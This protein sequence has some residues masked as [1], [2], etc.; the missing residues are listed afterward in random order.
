MVPVILILIIGLST[1]TLEER[2]IQASEVET[3]I[4]AGEPA[5]FDNCII[6][7]DLNLSALKID[8]PVHFNHT[9]FKGDAYFGSSAFKGDA[10]FGSSEFK[11][12]AYFGSSEFNGNADFL[13]SVFNGTAYFGYSFFK[14]YANFGASVFKGDADFWGSAF[15]GYAY[16]G[17]SVFKGDADFRASVFIG[18]ADFRASEFKGDADF[19][20]SEFKGD[21]DFRASEFKGDADFGYSAFNKNA[22]FIDSQFD[23]AASFNNASFSKGLLQVGE[24]AGFFGTLDLNKSSINSIDTYIRWKNINHLKFNIKTYNLLFDNYKKWR[25]FEDYNDCYY[26]FRKE[27]LFH[28]TLSFTKL[29][30]YFQW[31]LNGFGMKP[32]FPVVWSIGIILISGSIFYIANGI[33]RSNEKNATNVVYIPGYKIPRKPLKERIRR[34]IFQKRSISIGESMLFSA[35]YFSSGANSIISTTPIDLTPIG[36]SRY[37][38]VFE[39]LLGWVFFALFLAALGNTAIR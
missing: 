33:Q 5:E 8:G 16:F 6:E 27:L 18:D 12:D 17:P 36:V 24:D 2:I 28:E 9:T 26:T 3:I 31:I 25:L 1:G 10:Y 21:A 30:D 15:K 23:A 34:I 35:T 4:R 37:I 14:G 11:G 20:A 38:A 29:L 39:R 19:R 22:S 32:I 13:Y 7:G